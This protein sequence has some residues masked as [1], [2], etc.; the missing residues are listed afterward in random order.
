DYT[1]PED[2]TYRLEVSELLHRGGASFGYYVEVAS[3]PK[4]AV[5]IKP[6]AKTKEQ[7][8]VEQQSGAFAIDFQ[9]QRAGY[10]GPI[11]IGFAA[12]IPGLKLLNPRIDAKAKEGTIYVTADEKWQSESFTGLRFEAI[13]SDAPD[14]KVAVSSLA[15][16]RIKAPHIPFPA[17]GMNGLVTTAGVSASPPF[18]TFETS[19][20]PV[21]ARQQT[22]HTA[23]L[24][25]KRTQE[26]FKG[27]VSV[28]PYKQLPS[29]TSA[30]KPDKDT[31]AITWTR[32]SNTD[33]PQQL[34]LLA[35]AE[36][37]GRGR[38]HSQNVSVSWIDPLQVSIQPNSPLVVGSN[39]QVEVSFAWDAAATT[40]PLKLSWLNLPVGIVGPP[41]EVAA[42]I[43]AAK[44]ELQLTPEFVGS[45]VALQ[46]Q[47]TSQ[48]AGQPFTTQSEIATF[49]VIPAPTKL[50]VFPSVVELR[51]PKDFR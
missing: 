26:A 47:A 35:F 22:S 34:P 24:S 1:F 21:F 49:Q 16:H 29:W 50:E 15:L 38:M 17:S 32:S 41:L 5:A 40:Q 43:A 36:L 4:F 10:D 25:L 45:T 13:A 48:F 8:A 30:A 44:L 6:D 3:P 42:G 2:G 33:E 11:D 20:A 12:P 7:F 18:F 39:Q 37:N 23:T 9:I 28:L 27:A 46:L 31:Y 19:A 14:L 51:G